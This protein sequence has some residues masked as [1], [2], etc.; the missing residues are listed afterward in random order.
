LWFLIQNFEEK[1]QEPILYK[2]G[3][4]QY[5]AENKLIQEFI[6][7]YDCIRSIHISDK[8]LEK[9]LQNNILYNGNYF[10][11]LGYKAKCLEI[12]TN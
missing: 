12:A 4:G 8:T 10:K 3:V 5:D 11:L 2:N 1:N 7:N 9:A 6:C